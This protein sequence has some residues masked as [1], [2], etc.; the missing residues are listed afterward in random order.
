MR[1]LFTVMI[2]IIFCLHTYAS[3][4]EMWFKSI[5]V[6]PKDGDCLLK[7]ASARVG[8]RDYDCPSRCPNFCSQNFVTNALFN[9]QSV[10]YYPGLTKAERALASQY[11]AEAI[12][13][14]ISKEKTE[15]LTLDTFKV[16]HPNDESDA[17]RHFA[18]SCFLTMELGEEKALK[19]L[20]AHEQN[21]RMQNDAERSMDIANNKV[22]VSRCKNLNKA[23]ISNEDVR[24][25]GLEELKN[26]NLTIIK[27]RGLLK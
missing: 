24:N 23:K 5:G 19:F 11:P 8:M 27:S 16:N 25:M 22:G 10:V 20:D 4:C 1:I 14:Y 21:D 12:K 3:D 6:S 13:A 26:K 2:G 17:F 18:W 7:C 15:D 9:I